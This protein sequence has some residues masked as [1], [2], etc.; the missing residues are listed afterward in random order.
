MKTLKVILFLAVSLIISTS[1]AL[2]DFGLPTPV[3]EPASIILLGVGI[4]GLIVSG[5]KFKK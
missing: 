2:A 3:P 4:V 5:K 1:S